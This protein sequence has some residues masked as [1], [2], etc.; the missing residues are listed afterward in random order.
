MLLN[1][2]PSRIERQRKPAVPTWE[3]PL[4]FPMLR[5][6]QEDVT[7]KLTLLEYLNKDKAEIRTHTQNKLIS[8][9]VELN[10]YTT[11]RIDLMHAL[12]R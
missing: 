9:A 7:T 6:S 4:F 3:L 5:A 11:R 12:A 10:Y 8:L 1:E 2:L